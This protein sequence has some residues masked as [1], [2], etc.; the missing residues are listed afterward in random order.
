VGCF[1]KPPL[2]LKD[3]DIVTCAIE[4]IGQITNT[5]KESAVEKK[6]LMEVCQN[7]VTRSGSVAGAGADS[8]PAQ[9]SLQQNFN[10][11]AKKNVVVTGGA[12]GIG[13]AA[14]AQFCHEGANVAIFDIDE[15]KGASLAKEINEAVIPVSKGRVFFYAVDVQDKSSIVNAVTDFASKNGGIIDS[16]F[17][18]AV[19]F[20]SKGQNIFRSGFCSCKS[21]CICDFDCDTAAGVVAISI[22]MLCYIACFTN[23]SVTC[24]VML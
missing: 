12:S 23:H 1:R 21:F 16:L 8:P 14:V 7:L 19:D 6:R 22:D 10:R 13:A 11:F 24:L 2:W 9:S 3:G 17:N 5:V 20:N 4:G 15:Q 18:N